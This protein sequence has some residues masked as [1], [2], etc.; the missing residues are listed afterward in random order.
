MIID[1]DL[2]ISGVSSGYRFQEVVGLSDAY[3]G[4]GGIKDF[5]KTWN[6]ETAVYIYDE[7]GRLL[8]LNTFPGRRRRGAAASMR[9]LDVNPSSKQGKTRKHDSKVE[10]RKRMAKQSRNRNRPKK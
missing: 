8:G 4:G 5:F 1:E 9:I 7:Y 3:S 6:G 10:S 2:L